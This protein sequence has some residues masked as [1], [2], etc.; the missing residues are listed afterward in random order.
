MSDSMAN[1]RRFRTFNLI[2]ECN[3]EVLA[4]EINASLSSKHI[5]RILERVV[6][7]R[8]KPRIN[9]TDNRP[10]FTLKKN[11]FWEKTMES[12]SS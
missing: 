12:K 1:G 5:N 8:G 9:R 7:E 3:H 11:E 4:I 2:D 10:E 6:L